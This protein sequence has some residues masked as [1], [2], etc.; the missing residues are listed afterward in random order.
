MAHTLT[1]RTLL[2]AGAGVATVA[3]VGGLAARDLS[4]PAPKPAGPDVPVGDARLIRIASSARG[5]EV[6]F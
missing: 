5:R 3:V 2:T 4:R 6:D 1:R